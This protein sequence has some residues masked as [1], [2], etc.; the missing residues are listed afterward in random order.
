LPGDVCRETV[1]ADNFP[2][3]DVREKCS[4]EGTFFAGRRDFTGEFDQK[5]NTSGTGGN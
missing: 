5:R 2:W 4:V 3:E 1:E